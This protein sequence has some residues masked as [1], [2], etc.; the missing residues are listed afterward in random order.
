MTHGGSGPK[1]HYRCRR[2]NAEPGQHAGEVTIGAKGIERHLVCRIFAVLQS[3]DDES[4]R[5]VLAE[6]A[7]R[8][9]V[10][11]EKTES[12]AVAQERARL[13]SERASLRRSREVHHAERRNALLTG[14]FVDDFARESWEETEGALAERMRAVDLRLAQIGDSGTAG[15]PYAEWVRAGV[16]PVGPGSWWAEVDF[17]TKRAF[18][19]LFLDRVSVT[20][21]RRW[22]GQGVPVEARVTVTWAGGVDLDGPATLG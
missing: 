14:A 10:E 1:K 6:A 8:Y 4:T 11:R 21:A 9:A 15:L 16:D 5:A 13:L 2:R 20:K 19:R 22:A 17:E 12:P 7:A 18:F 3:A